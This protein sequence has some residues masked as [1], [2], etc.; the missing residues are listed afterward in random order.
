MGCCQHYG[1]AI[2]ALS[3]G[4]LRAFG[5]LLA[6]FQ[7]NTT[8]AKPPALI[9]LEEPEMALHPA[10]AGILLGALREASVTSQVMV[11]SHSADLLDDASIPT[12]AIFAVDNEEGVTRIA[13]IDEAG[14]SVLK[15]RLFTAGELLRQ[16]QIAPDPVA[17]ADLEGEAQRLFELNGK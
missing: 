2:S 12:D 8:N 13:P 15:D 17:V 1:N 4:T 7:G 6:L 3:D 16:N 14:R 10:A 11:T 5:L 9:G